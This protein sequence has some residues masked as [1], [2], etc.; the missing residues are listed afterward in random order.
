[1]GLVC[2]LTFVPWELTIEGRGSL[3]PEDRR[4][5]YAPLQGTIVKVPVD[6]G[7]VVKEGDLL[8]KMDS[9]DLEKDLQKLISQEQ[10]AKARQGQFRAQAEKANSSRGEEYTQ[11][12]AQEQEAK[13]QAESARK[14]IEII[15]EQL[16]MMEI[17]SPQDGE[18]TT[19]EPQKTLQ[20][21]PVEVGQELLQVAATGGDW[22]MEVDVPDDDMG[23]ILEA[24][25]RLEADVKAGR[26]PP[27]STCRRTSSR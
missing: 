11:L 20:G 2:V 3:L 7:S 12:K 24:K 25:S 19:W 22:V 6:H 5:L 26:K 23:P 21:R 1:M 17:R 16:A 13:I 15:K 10:E 8:A 9:L 18:V 14:Q 27:G 4:T